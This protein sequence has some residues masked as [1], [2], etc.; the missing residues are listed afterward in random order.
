MLVIAPNERELKIE[1]GYGL[2]P[3]LTDSRSG[4]IIRNIITPEFKKDDYDTGIIS[5]VNAII[6]VTSK[7]PTL[8]DNQTPIDIDSG[9]LDSL[10]F[11][12]MAL[13]YLSAFLARSKRWWPGGVI[14]GILG[15]F[16]SL[17]GGVILAL[18]GLLL[19][20]LLSKNYKNR[21]KH[22]LPTSWISSIGG[23][24]GGRSSG[25]FGGF[26]GGSSGGGGS[27]GSW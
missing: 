17:A 13:V 20:Y 4:T 1:V 10:I 12:S 25:G 5:G 21:K 14:G 11:L 26:S 19:D 6:E 24:S 3:V 22:G 23:F 16:I 7:D 27:S 8:Y 9:S 18:L 15:L 2:E